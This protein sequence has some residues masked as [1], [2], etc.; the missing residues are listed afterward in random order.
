MK[1]TIA[2]DF[3]GVIHAYSKGWENGALYDSPVAGAEDALYRL[4][5]H[6]KIVILTARPQHQFPLIRSWMDRYF[7]SPDFHFDITNVKPA[8]VAYIDDRGI[9]FINWTQ[10]L[11]VL[12]K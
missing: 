8:A 5:R 3:D 6:Y 11:N 9:K 1:P 10:V 4:A 7:K 12:I 2:V